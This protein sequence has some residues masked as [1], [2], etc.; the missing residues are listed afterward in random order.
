MEVPV[1]LSVDK[2]HRM[3]S[4]A[5]PLLAMLSPAEVNPGVH[6]VPEGCWV[7]WS[8]RVDWLVVLECV[9]TSAWVLAMYCQASSSSA[10]S[11][12]T[13]DPANQSQ[14]VSTLP[15]AVDDF[16]TV[17]L[18]KYIMEVVTFAG[19]RAASP[20]F[21]L[22]SICARIF[23]TPNCVFRLQTYD[24][25][26]LHASD[27]ISEDVLLGLR[28][29]SAS[30]YQERTFIDTVW[31]CVVAVR[32]ERYALQSRP[33]RFVGGHWR[34]RPSVCSDAQDCAACKAV[35]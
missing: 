6:Q 11:A 23:D 5:A 15:R 3:L 30:L 14:P 9:L 25:D 31:S 21:V 19:R 35:G 7:H 28:R 34:A 4:A 1:Q 12:T 24:N 27:G 16:L 29:F 2:P 33:G 13:S 10:T 22:Q 8:C 20:S 17:R 26:S 32:R 18:E